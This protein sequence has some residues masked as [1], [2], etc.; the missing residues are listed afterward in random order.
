M[1]KPQYLFDSAEEL[2]ERLAGRKIALFLDYD[3][4]LT[5]IVDDPAEAVLAEDMRQIIEQLAQRCVVA[6]VSGRDLQV[7]KEFVQLGGVYYAGS[8]GFDI[9]GP[10]GMTEQN[11]Q[12]ADC[13]ANLDRAAGELA[14]QLIDIDGSQIERKGFAVAV[15]YRNVEP[16]KTSRVEQIVK[17]TADKYEN[18]RLGL[19]KKVFE[20]QPNVDWHKGKAVLWLIDVLGLDEDQ[21]VPIYVGDDVTDEDAFRALAGRGIGVYVGRLSRQTAAEYYVKDVDDVKRLLGTLLESVR[22]D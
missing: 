3:G 15:H 17:E 14:Q 22:S 1:D 16:S 5:P 13:L 7:L 19:G 20:L 12:G 6:M 10:G 11:Q 4:T 9:T 18:L 21:T 2:Q 8:H